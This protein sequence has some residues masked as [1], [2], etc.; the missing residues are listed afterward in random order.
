MANLRA[1]ITIGQRGPAG[2]QGQRGPAGPQGPQ[3][4]QGAN[5]DGTTQQLTIQTSDNTIE[6]NANIYYNITL[7]NST[8]TT[9]SLIAGDE[10]LANEYLGQITVANDGLIFRINNVRWLIGDDIVYTDTDI[11]MNTGKTY[12]FSI[13]N[14]IGLMVVL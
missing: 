5:G 13:V 3:G 2:P 6:L 11:T 4:P 10:S 7:N 1:D 12:L 9:V 8:E 14:N